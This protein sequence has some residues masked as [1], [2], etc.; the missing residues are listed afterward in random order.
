VLCTSSSW[1]S[2]EEAAMQGQAYLRGDAGLELLDPSDSPVP[3]SAIDPDAG[4]T[5]ECAEIPAEAV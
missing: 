5:V 2:A 3:A 4:M 1:E